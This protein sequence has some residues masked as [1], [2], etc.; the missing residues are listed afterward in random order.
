MHQN[1]KGHTS[2][3]FGMVHS[4]RTVVDVLHTLGPDLALSVKLSALSHIVHTLLCV[5]MTLHHIST[6]HSPFSSWLMSNFSSVL[7]VVCQFFTW[8]ALSDVDLHF[9]LT[10]RKANV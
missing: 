4:N 10:V 8:I 6:I 9:S 3:V 1:C 7:I 2:I 5:K